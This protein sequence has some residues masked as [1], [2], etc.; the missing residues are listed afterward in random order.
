M[1]L[2]WRRE[3]LAGFDEGLEAGE[4]RSPALHGAVGDIG[5]PFAAVIFADGDAGC[6][7]GRGVDQEFDAVGRRVVVKAPGEQE[8][9][10]RLLREN[11][12]GDG[13]PLI[14]GVANPALAQC[15]LAT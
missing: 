8:P 15:A 13:R 7:V 11:N 2:E 6:A 3:W 10:R 14:G 4:E 5:R 9:V 1:A 12:A